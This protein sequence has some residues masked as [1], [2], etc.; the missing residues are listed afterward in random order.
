MA[1]KLELEKLNKDLE[2]ANKELEKINKVLDI[3]KRNMKKEIIKVEGQKEKLDIKLADMHKTN[4]VITGNEHVVR[5]Q[6]IILE[7]A[8]KDANQKTIYLEEQ[9]NNLSDL[10][11]SLLRVFKE[12]NALLGMFHR[13][14]LYSEEHIENLTNKFNERNKGGDNK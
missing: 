1:T 9:L 4:L 12:Q 3:D 14:T 2:K 6:N 13:N 10:F 8:S 11:N 5:K 7:Q